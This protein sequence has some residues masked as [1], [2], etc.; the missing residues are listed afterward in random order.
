MKVDLQPNPDNCCLLQAAE[1]GAALAEQGDRLEAMAQR[2][3]A[4]TDTILTLQDALQQAQQADAAQRDQVECPAAA[5]AC[6]HQL[7][8]YRTCVRSTCNAALTGA[9]PDAYLGLW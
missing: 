7:N 6:C 5:G 2:A 9:R 4:A 3:A 1:N 8:M